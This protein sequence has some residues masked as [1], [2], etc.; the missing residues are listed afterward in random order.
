[1]ED[2][3]TGRGTQ[4][5]GICGKT[6]SPRLHLQ[7]LPQPALPPPQ[8]GWNLGSN[9]LPERR[10]AVK[11][12]GIQVEILAGTL[13]GDPCGSSV[14]CSNRSCRPL[15]CAPARYWRSEQT[16]VPLGSPKGFSA[17]AQRV[18]GDCPSG[19]V[20]CP[21][22]ELLR[23]LCAP[24]WHHFLACR[25]GL[26]LPFSTC[27]LCPGTAAILRVTL[28][29][30]PLNPFALLPS[31]DPRFR[32]LLSPEPE[33]SGPLRAPLKARPRCGST[34]AGTRAGLRWAWP[35]LSASNAFRVFCGLGTRTLGS[36][37]RSGW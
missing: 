31:H 4:A 9:H 22:G 6:G 2:S 33:S 10:C 13:E 36:G 11:L 37:L 24:W 8:V 12:G 5:R 7:W 30:S 25:L 29:C 35:S 14:Q 27:V 21:P 18:P 3:C 17:L 20:A 15:P 34:F 32:M 19:G 23:R 26:S 16:E 1:M 28:S